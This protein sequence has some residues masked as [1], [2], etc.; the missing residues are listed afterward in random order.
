M[1][2]TF[3]GTGA[4]ES[5]PAFRCMCKICENARQ[6]RGKELRQ[7]SSAYI[8][9]KYGSSILVDMPSHVKMALDMYGLNDKNLD[10]IVFS[11]YHLD[12]MGGASALLNILDKNGHI[13]DNYIKAYMPEDCYKTL[14]DGMFYDQ[15]DLNKIDYSKYYSLEILRNLEKASCSCGKLHFQALD[16]N[17]LIDHPGVPYKRECHGYL[18]SEDE[19]NIAYLV[20]S[21]SMLPDATVK[22]LTGDGMELDCL[23]N[24]CTFDVYPGQKMGHSTLESVV[25]TRELLKPKQMILTHIS[26]RNF[27]HEKL[28]EYM[29]KYDIKVAWDGMALEI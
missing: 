8:E 14:F 6:K 20:D 10:A 13:G 22:A 4:A 23:I 9:G 11:H 7:N 3:L 17:H 28:V 12:H 15:I 16:T 21:S 24:E 18:F 2:I 25:K 26:H 5:I 19:K 27:T 29:A 1:K